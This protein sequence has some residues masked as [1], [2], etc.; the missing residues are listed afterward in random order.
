MPRYQTAC[1]KTERR[2]GPSLQ[3]VCIP[4]CRQAMAC[5]CVSSKSV[6]EL[7][8]AVRSRRRYGAR[9]APSLGRPAQSPPDR[10]EASPT[11]ITDHTPEIVRPWLVVAA[12]RMV[13]GW[14][15]HFFAQIVHNLSRLSAFNGDISSS[16]S[17]A[18]KAK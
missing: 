7:V 11:F 10:W 9:R 3:I 2:S 14:A 4:A 18:N 15:A 1:Q 5:H 6:V 13:P 8:Y 12:L 17:L 16:Y